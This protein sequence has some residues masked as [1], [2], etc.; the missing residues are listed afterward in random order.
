M[1]MKATHKL[2]SLASGAMWDL[3]NT[4]HGLYCKMTSPRQS[5]MWEKSQWVGMDYYTNH[6][7]FSCK[8]I[9]KFKGNK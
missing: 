6:E 7:D 8:Q 9:N 5:D 2:V 3:A 1:E 4:E